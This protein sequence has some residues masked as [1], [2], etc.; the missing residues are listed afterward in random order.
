VISVAAYR[1]SAVPEAEL[2]PLLDR[3]RR[4]EIDV[5]TF[6]APSQVQALA[7]ALGDAAAEVLGRPPLV[8]AVGPTTA[9]ALRER[10]LR[11][12]L[13]PATPAAGALAQSIADHF[14]EEH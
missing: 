14:R 1:T 8:A 3:L 10:G 11:V 7:T 5:V 2:A 4:A 12:D 13:V 6:F 9:A